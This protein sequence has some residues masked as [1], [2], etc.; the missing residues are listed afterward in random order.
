MSIVTN[1]NITITSKCFGVKRGCPQGGI[2]S[3]FLWNLV[4]DDLLKLS[5]KE[6]PGYLQAFA[7][8]L[9]IFAEGN[10]T[11]TIW[12]RTQK[13][14]KTIENWCN[15]KGLNISSLKTKTIMFTWNKKWSL[16]PI[17]VD[18]RA[19]VLSDSVKFLGVTLDC[20]INFNT[21]IDKITNKAIA[22]LMQCK[23]AV[24]PTWGLTPKT[25]NWIYKTIVRPILTYSVVLWIR[26]LNNKLNAKNSKEYK[27]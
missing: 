9:V 10:D 14:I 19:I 6:T 17:V 13:T 12:Q 7:D 22:T 27:H 15:S 2:I 11:E 24:G 1:R 23:R 8:D 21:H 25:C 26:A 5:D 3:P 16:R 4:V 20:K 18:G